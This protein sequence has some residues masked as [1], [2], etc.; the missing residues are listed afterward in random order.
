MEEKSI[1]KGSLRMLLGLSV[2]AAA[3]IAGGQIGDNIVDVVNNTDPF[4]L[5]VAAVSTATLGNG[6]YQTIMGYCQ[7]AGKGRYA[8]RE[9]EN[10]Q[11]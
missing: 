6:F 7:A 5:S 2:T 1:I 10:P 11:N 3:F 8:Q 4:Q 9:L